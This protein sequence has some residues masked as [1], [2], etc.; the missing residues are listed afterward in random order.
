MA[1]DVQWGWRFLFLSSSLS[2]T[3]SPS[4][5]SSVSPRH[6]LLLPFFSFSPGNNLCCTKKI[7][8]LCRARECFSAHVCER[9]CAWTHACVLSP[10]LLSVWCVIKGPLDWDEQPI[11]RA[12]SAARRCVYVRVCVQTWIVFCACL[13]PA[14]FVCSGA[15]SVASSPCRDKVLYEHLSGDMI[16]CLSV[17]LSLCVRMVN[18][19]QKHAHTDTRTQTVM[20]ALRE[21]V[22]QM[23]ETFIFIHEQTEQ[24]VNLRIYM[25]ALVF[26]SCRSF[27]KCMK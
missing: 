20:D 9:P 15:S 13:V 16:P 5:C 21:S 11:R 26:G 19:L 8:T 22:S 24:N 10:R 3:R 6:S 1:T 14:Q 12:G 2:L 25:R 7:F 27:S 23:Q 18:W 17:C 4:I